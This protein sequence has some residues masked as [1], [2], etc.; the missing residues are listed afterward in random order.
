MAAALFSTL[1]NRISPN[2]PGAPQP[3]LIAHIRDAAIEVCERTLAWRYEQADVTLTTAVESTAFVPDT[4][5]EVHAIISAS[6]NGVNAPALTLEQVHARYPK[7]PDNSS[8]ELGQPQYVT[9]IDPDT[10]YH[11]PIADTAATYTVKMFLALKPIRTA[12]GMEKAFLDELEDVIVHGALQRLLVLPERTW[13]DK[14]LAAYH[15]KQF[16]F[17]V[18]ERRARVNV[19]PGRAALTAYAPPLA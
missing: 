8:S 9:H 16:V 1:V 12:T 5:S 19:G 11:V 4:D 6:I 13:S 14:E 3:V 10:F 15:A 2:A 17:K 7:F 18:S